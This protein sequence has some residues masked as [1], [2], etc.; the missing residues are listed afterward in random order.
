MRKKTPKQE[1][2]IRDVEILSI[3]ESMLKK[4]NAH[5]PPTDSALNECRTFSLQTPERK[6]DY[7]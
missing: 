3:S 4:A 1:N 7:Q 2:D 6:S 5:I